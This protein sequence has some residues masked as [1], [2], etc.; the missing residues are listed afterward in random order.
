M[1]TIIIISC[2]FVLCGHTMDQ[3]QTNNNHFLNGFWC[4]FDFFLF[5]SKICG[6]KETGN[7]SR[8]YSSCVSLLLLSHR[9]E[10]DYNNTCRGGRG[11]NYRPMEME[12]LC[13]FGQDFRHTPR[14]RDAKNRMRIKST[15]WRLEA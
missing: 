12:P 15:G 7:E 13:C 14:E 2:A 11:R 9:C 4:G 1:I 5:L 3:Q 10:N 6:A 8:S